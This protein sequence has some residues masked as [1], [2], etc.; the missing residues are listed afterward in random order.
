[1]NINDLTKWIS[2]NGDKILHD[3]AGEL[4]AGFSTILMV[5]L[6]INPY[7]SIGVGF[8]VATIVGYLKE[9][10]YDKKMGKGTYDMDDFKAVV[11]GA[12]RMSIILVLYT[13]FI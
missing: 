2:N 8:I 3:Y 5:L 1:M 4:I 9:W 6:T 10:L 11:V 7:L 12:L 13:A